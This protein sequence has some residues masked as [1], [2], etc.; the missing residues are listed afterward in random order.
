ESTQGLKRFSHQEGGTLFM[1]LLSSLKALL[2]RYTGQE[3]LIIG[4]PVAGRT[5]RFGRSDW[6]LYQYA[7]TAKCGSFRG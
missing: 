6:F 4:I 5:F 7:C 3:D 1:G 2:Y